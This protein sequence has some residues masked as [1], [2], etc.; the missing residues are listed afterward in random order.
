MAPEP[1]E[2][3]AL[4]NDPVIGRK[5]K[6]RKQREQEPPKEPEP[7]FT[8]T[9]LIVLFDIARDALRKVFRLRY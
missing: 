7:S 9:L 2:H 3:P 4:V 8:L 5:K 6:S 1:W